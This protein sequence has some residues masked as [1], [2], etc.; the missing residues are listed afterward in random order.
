MFNKFSAVGVF[1]F[2][3]SG[4][5]PYGSLAEN[6][7][8]KI[9]EELLV[10]REELKD[11]EPQI[12]NLTQSLNKQQQALEDADQK[13]QD[14]TNLLKDINSELSTDNKNISKFRSDC[15]Q[16]EEKYFNDITEHRERFLAQRKK[17]CKEKSIPGQ[18]VYILKIS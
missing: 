15:E 16:L 14:F 1:C 9:D 17:L 18:Y 4:L 7:L 8:K 5:S 10:K 2:H 3:T 6:D 12:S 11:I 13:V